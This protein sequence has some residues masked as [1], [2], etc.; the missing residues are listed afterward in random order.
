MVPVHA[1]EASTLTFVGHR[2][3]MYRAS[4]D[5]EHPRASRKEIMGK[6]ADWR[7]MVILGS[8]FS[9]IFSTEIMQPALKSCLIVLLFETVMCIALSLRGIEAF[10][11]YLSRS[12]VVARITQ[13]MWKVSQDAMKRAMQLLIIDSLLTGHTHFMEW[14]ANWQ[15][16][17]LRRL[18]DGTYTNRLDRIFCGCCLGQLLSQLCLCQAP[19]LGHSMQ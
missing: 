2:W 1:L 11:R 15:P 4:Q 8:S 5:Y 12:R 14:T 3:G 7:I 6:N 19:W 18:H 16:S 13:T 17:S 10:A 9:L